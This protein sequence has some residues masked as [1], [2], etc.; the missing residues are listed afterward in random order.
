MHFQKCNIKIWNALAKVQS[1][2][3]DLFPRVGAIDVER[4]NL[5]SP[6]WAE[7]TSEGIG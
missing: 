3:M 7:K 2:D 6:E 1:Q 5:L 4:M